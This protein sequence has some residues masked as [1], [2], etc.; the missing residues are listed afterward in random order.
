MLF[1][2]SFQCRLVITDVQEGTPAFGQLKVGDTIQAVNNRQVQNL[3]NFYQVLRAAHPIAMISIKRPRTRDEIPPEVRQEV[4]DNL[5]A[6]IATVIT[7]RPGYHYQVGFTLSPLKLKINILILFFFYSWS[8]L[9]DSAA[10]DL[11]WPSRQGTT[12]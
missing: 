3:R 11:G 1:P 12:A 9:S 4:N 7:R 8:R 5:P 6:E 10:S 2:L